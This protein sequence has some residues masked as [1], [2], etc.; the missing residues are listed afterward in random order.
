MV[1]NYHIAIPTIKQPTKY[2]APRAKVRRLGASAQL[3]RFF[4]SR[5]L[6]WSSSLC[7]Y[8][9]LDTL[10]HIYVRYVTLSCW[11]CWVINRV[12]DVVCNITIFSC[13][14]MEWREATK[15]ET[16]QNHARN[17]CYEYVCFEYK[18]LLLELSS[19]ALND[20]TCFWIAILMNLKSQQISRGDCWDL[21]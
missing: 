4:F 14:I 12:S 7:I 11:S 20:T 21:V 10:F 16:L 6:A 18:R 15:N 19:C 13:N 17:F 1:I 9:S 3:L 5:A 8:T 2:H